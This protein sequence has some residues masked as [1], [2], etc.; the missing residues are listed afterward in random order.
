MVRRLYATLSVPVPP[1]SLVIPPSRLYSYLSP[2]PT[3]LP[4]SPSLTLSPSP[5][6]LPSLSLP[7]IVGFRVEPM[8]IKHTWEGD[9]DYVPG[10]TILKTCND[11]N[12]AQ[13]DVRN[14]QSGQW[15]WPASIHIDT[16]AL[17]YTTFYRPLYFTSVSSCLVL[18]PLSHYILST[19]IVSHSALLLLHSAPQGSISSLL[20][21]Y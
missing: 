13:D 17:P 15:E 9:A 8:S 11:Q 7:Q 1:L 12:P 21:S 4:F 10:K 18:S 20:Y 2:F 3:S 6:F 19:N 5:S 14:F 16:D